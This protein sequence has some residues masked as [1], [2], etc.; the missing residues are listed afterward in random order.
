MRGHV[1]TIRRESVFRLWSLLPARFV[2]DESRR[3]VHLL[4]KRTDLG[5]CRPEGWCSASQR[6]AQDCHP[7]LP[8]LMHNMHNLHTEEFSQVIICERLVAENGAFEKRMY[9]HNQRPSPANV[10][11]RM[12]RDTPA[13]VDAPLCHKS[14][15]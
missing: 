14:P 13:H 7:Q 11:H 12:R 2:I 9:M 3:F 6:K 8:A 15:A 5:V 1:M 10:I 4:T